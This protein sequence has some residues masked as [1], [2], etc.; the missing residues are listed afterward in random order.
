SAVTISSPPNA[1][2]EVEAQAQGTLAAS[3]RGADA[4]AAA[5]HR[6]VG[7]LRLLRV[8][9]LRRARDHPQLHGRLRGVPELAAVRRAGAHGS[10]VRRLDPD[11]LT[12]GRGILATWHRIEWT[13]SRACA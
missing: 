5:A 1:R 3:P 6:A 12:R 13:S 7:S 2:V 11:V 10:G 9:G 4:A 8:H